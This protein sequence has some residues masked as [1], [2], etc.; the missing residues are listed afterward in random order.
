[1]PLGQRGAVVIEDDRLMASLIASLLEEHG[2]EC[3]I[4]HSA[5]EAKAVLK[6]SDIDVAIVDIH[7][8]NGPSGIQLAKSAE[9]THPGV[10]VVFV[11]NTPEYISL[12]VQEADLPRHF[13][14]AGKDQLASGEELL[15]AIESVLSDKRTPVRHDKAR[16]PLLSGLTGLQREVLK[17]VA[18]GLT[19]QAIADKR[20]VNKRSVERTLQTIFERLD[21]PDNDTTN[22]RATA[23]RRYVEAVGFPPS[24]G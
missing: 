18:A 5:K 20:Q 15:D 14:V 19:N 11:T 7:L 12:D 9:R 8:G 22:R 21:I 4:A 16:S 17:D 3:H 6:S 1:M 24:D 23:I 2:F 13:G 10:G